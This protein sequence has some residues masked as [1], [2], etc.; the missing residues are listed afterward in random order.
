MNEHKGSDKNAKV[1]IAIAEVLAG[2]EPR[3]DKEKVDEV[4]P[5]NDGRLENGSR[6]E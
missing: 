3:A 6:A 5:R 4:N 2:G 1:M